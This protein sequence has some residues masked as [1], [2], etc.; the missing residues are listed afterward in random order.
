MKMSAVE[1]SH[2]PFWCR[3]ST[4]SLYRAS[5]RSPSPDYYFQIH[6]MSGPIRTSSTNHRANPLDPNDKPPRPPNAWILYRSDKMKELRAPPGAPKKP[7]SEISKTIAEM[8]RNESD[9]MRRYYEHLSEIKKAEHQAE[10]PGYRFQ[11][12]K[13]EEKERIRAEKQALKETERALKKA[14]G[15]GA[16]RPAGEGPLP[17]FTTEARLLPGQVSNVAS[18]ASD[19]MMAGPSSQPPAAGPSSEPSSHLTPSTDATSTT[20]SHTPSPY[21]PPPTNAAVPQ[22]VAPKPG[23]VQRPPSPSDWPSSFPA[24]AGP[25]NAD[26]NSLGLEF[27]PNAPFADPSDP[28]V[29][30]S[31]FIWPIMYLHARAS[32]TS[33]FLFH[34]I[35]SN[36]KHRFRGTRAILLLSQASPKISSPS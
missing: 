15:R 23:V 13:R 26:N 11:P 2:Q 28:N 19:P 6:F 5:S 7:Q 4:P 33:L 10:F 21:P 17:L 8:W 14:R 34:R 16:R 9:E 1:S 22:I 36:T 18:S 3:A 12:I 25:S 27:D 24:E 29:R 31:R 35:C 32:H 30:V 20:R